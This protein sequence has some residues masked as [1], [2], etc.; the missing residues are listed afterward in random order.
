MQSAE[1]L[2]SFRLSY[3]SGRRRGPAGWL[4]AWQVPQ[5]LAQTSSV[6]EQEAVG[7]S[8]KF[9]LEVWEGLCLIG[10]NKKDGK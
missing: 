2:A 7:G 4:P 3:V 5:Q 9:I 6:S 10:K 8:L 1:R